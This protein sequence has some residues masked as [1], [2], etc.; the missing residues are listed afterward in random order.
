MKSFYLLTDLPT[1]TPNGKYWVYTM[2]ERVAMLAVPRGLL[3]A[4]SDGVIQQSST[5]CPATTSEN[6][7]RAM[8]NI[9]MVIMTTD[10]KK[11]QIHLPEIL[12]R[13][14]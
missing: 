3:K 6:L 8:V 5:V 2:D 11:D 12:R 1:C 9:I 10:Y 13:I 4:V 7:I 14:R